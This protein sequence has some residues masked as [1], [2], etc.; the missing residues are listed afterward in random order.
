MSASIVGAVSLFVRSV[1]H[2]N[3]FGPEPT[4]GRP[5]DGVRRR[6]QEQAA[7]EPARAQPRE[8]HWKSPEPLTRPAPACEPSSCCRH[9]QRRTRQSC[10]YPRARSCAAAWHAHAPKRPSPKLTF[11]EPVLDPRAFALGSIGEP[12]GDARTAHTH[13]HPWR[14]AVHLQRGGHAVDDLPERVGRL[15]LDRVD[16]IRR[17]VHG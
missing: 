7:R 4:G 5:I 12:H 15:H 14:R 17:P 13:A 9:C 10:S 6:E 11:T 2:R 1:V 16:T 3:E 8:A